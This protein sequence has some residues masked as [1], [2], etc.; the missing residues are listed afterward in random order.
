[1]KCEIIVGQL[2]SRPCSKKAELSCPQCSLNVCAAHFDQEADRCFGC[3]GAIE[4]SKG[5]MDVEELFHFEQAELRV[6][7]TEKHVDVT[8]EYLDS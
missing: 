2:I 3:S 4:E 5:M 6:F 8:Y 7:D 1:M